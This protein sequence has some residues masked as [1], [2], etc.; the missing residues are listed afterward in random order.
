MR[1]VSPRFCTTRQETVA[2][3]VTGSSGRL[4]PAFQSLFAECLRVAGVPVVRG[5][6]LRFP[7]LDNQAAF[8]AMNVPGRIQQFAHQIGAIG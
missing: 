5:P 4:K 6:A 3:E 7:L 2:I 8:T 1:L